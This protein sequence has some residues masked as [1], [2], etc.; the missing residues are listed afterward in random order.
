LL[1]IF[2][3]GS[4]DI[5]LAHALETARATGRSVGLVFVDIDHFKRINDSLGHQAGDVVLRDVSRVLAEAARGRGEAYR[6]GGEELAVL[7]PDADAR[8]VAAVAEE[9]RRAVEQRQFEGGMRVTVSCGAASFPEHA[10]TPHDL[11]AAADAAVYRAKAAGRNVVRVV[12]NEGD[13]HG[14]EPDAA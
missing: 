9:I 2:D 8:A 7:L 11:V 3:K 5:D 10:A 14:S 6:W 12:G 1:G 4:F 13:R